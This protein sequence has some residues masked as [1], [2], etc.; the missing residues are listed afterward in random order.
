MSLKTRL[1]LLISGLF[2]CFAFISSFMESSVMKRGIAKA[3]QNMRSQIF[4]LNEQNREDLENFVKWLLAD[5]DT[6]INAVLNH[7]TNL[8]FE[9]LRYG[10]TAHNIKEGTWLSSSELLLNFNWIDF[11]QSTIP[12]Q[13]ATIV[14]HTDAINASY[15][16]PINEDL[17]WVF[18]QG[19]PQPYLAILVPYQEDA[20]RL[21]SQE[22]S[23]IVSGID[24][25]PYLLFD[26]Q[27]LMQGKTKPLQAINLQPISLPWAE[28]YFFHIN[29][30]PDAFNNALGQLESR[31]LKPPLE[32]YGQ[33]QKDIETGLADQG[34]N[35]FK[36]PSRSLLKTPSMDLFLEAHLESIIERYTEVNLIWILLTLFHSGMFGDELF[37]FPAPVGISLFYVQND[38]G[39]AIL[40]KDVLYPEAFF[41]DQRYYEKNSVPSQTS[42]LATS[43]AIIT[44][45]NS[46]QIYFGNTAR[47]LVKK[48]SSDNNGALEETQGFLTLGVNCNRVLEK[49]MLAVKQPSLLVHGGKIVSAYDRHGKMQGDLSAIP[50]DQMLQIQSGIISWNQVNYYYMHL[51]PFSEIDLHFFLLNP[52]S[53]EFALLSSLES[54]SRNIVKSVLENI[55][56]NGAILLVIVLLVCLKVSSSITNPIVAL[57][58]DTKKVA[59]GKLDEVV[60]PQPKNQDEI[61]V[62]CRSFQE[63][64]NGLKEK[65]KMKGVLNKVV[66]EEI[67]T[68]ILKG[69][70]H[71]GG[72]E[73]KVT[74]LFAD[75]RGFTALTEKMAPHDVIKLLNTCMTKIAEAIDLHKGIID[76]FIGDEVM[77]LFGAPLEVP[78]DAFQA[79]KCAVDI[80]AKLNEWNAQRQALNLPIIEMGIGIHTGQVLVGNMG[81]EK[82][83]NYTATGSNVNLAARLCSA[84]KGMEILISQA[85]LE[86][87]GVEQS[88]T[89]EKLPPISLKGFTQPIPVNRILSIKTIQKDR[90]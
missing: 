59:Q 16:I 53:K 6:N 10:P 15:R 21:T 43:L 28:H 40:S 17:A 89:Y 9:N 24:P 4:K 36:I 20:T 61:A 75:I 78:N 86:E 54:E 58:K 25:R 74:V 19:N 39:V 27:K 51:H 87:P 45:S 64:V 84:A 65:E 62:L 80:V 71:L 63:M 38:L 33:V 83:L 82:R 47:Y 26:V 3:Q 60:I 67:A 22:P 13:E 76:K 14:P 32:A 31:S 23:E 49:V 56:F 77:A 37:S 69:T 46:D 41:D 8:K 88:I 12:D 11:L 1:F 90:T 44:P 2:V 42:D 52:E 7:T 73:K 50:I 18:F 55:H 66:S 79:I 48:P 57:A 30:I 34:G 70:V 85:T 72:E 81:A 29:G 5:T 68:E 35:Y